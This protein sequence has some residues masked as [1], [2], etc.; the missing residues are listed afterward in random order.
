MEALTPK[1]CAHLNN[2]AFA[3]LPD[4]QGSSLVRDLQEAANKGN[5]KAVASKNLINAVLQDLTTIPPHQD[6]GMYG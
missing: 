4:R 1:F 2:S 6:W 5:W 3:S